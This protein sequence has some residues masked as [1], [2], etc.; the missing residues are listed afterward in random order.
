MLENSHATDYDNWWRS[1]H[2]INSSEPGTAFR[3]EWIIRKIKRMGAKS[4]VDCGCG[5]AILLRKIRADPELSSI[6]LAGFDVSEQ[7]IEWNRKAL[8]DIEFFTLN[9][10][11]PSEFQGQFDVAISSE[12]IEHIENWRMAVAS[13]AALVRPGGSVI[14]TTQAGKRYPHHLALGH[15]RHFEKQDIERE[16]KNQNFSIIESTYCG[17]P[18]MNL[19][20]ELVSLFNANDEDLMSLQ[21]ETLTRRL[22]FKAFRT[23]YG[24]SSKSRGPQIVIIGQKNAGASGDLPRQYRDEWAGANS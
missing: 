10:N 9:L 19:K 11:A 1:F 8:E 17:W 14:I 18:F 15:L 16:L 2:A 23:L 22:V 12:V 24:L 4:V 21:K 6:R 13:I 20:N 5:A 3:A 7:V